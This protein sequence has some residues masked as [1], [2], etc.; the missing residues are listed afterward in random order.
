MDNKIL[1]DIVAGL[2]DE[3]KNE[4]VKAV[5]EFD[6]TKLRLMVSSEIDLLVKPLNDEIK[7]TSSLWVKIRNRIYIAVLNHS[8]D[9]V[10]NKLKQSILK[11]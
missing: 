9:L 2:A 6:D 1:K 10:L 11:L 3:V 7:T 4:A 8:V 5:K